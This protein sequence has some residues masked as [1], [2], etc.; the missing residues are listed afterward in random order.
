MAIAKR[1]DRPAKTVKIPVCID[2]GASRLL[3]ALADPSG[4]CSVRELVSQDPP[5]SAQS[6]CF[7]PCFLE[8]VRG[9]RDL[10]RH[11]ASTGQISQVLN[12]SIVVVDR[13]KPRHG[14]RGIIAWEINGQLFGQAD[15][16]FEFA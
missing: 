14:K 3:D 16:P 15:R 6:R 4:K 11:S 8:T 1:L 12:F 5:D 7:A 2:I 10:L 9:V 13:L